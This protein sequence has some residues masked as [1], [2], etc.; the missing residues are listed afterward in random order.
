[1]SPS[2]GAPN[3]VKNALKPHPEA[4][5]EAT[6]SRRV[7]GETREPAWWRTAAAA[8]SAVSSPDPTRTTFRE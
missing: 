3:S 4:A 5:D 7:P 6:V 1:M 2:G 8:P